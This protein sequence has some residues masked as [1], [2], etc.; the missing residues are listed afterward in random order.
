MREGFAIRSN[1]KGGMDGDGEAEEE[2]KKKEEEQ[3]ESKAT[4]H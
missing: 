3:R 2:D 1:S 4:G